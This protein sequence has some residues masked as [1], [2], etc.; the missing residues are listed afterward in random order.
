M[1]SGSPKLVNNFGQQIFHQSSLIMELNLKIELGI[2][3][4]KINVQKFVKVGL[5]QVRQKNG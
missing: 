5:L 1:I 4:Q 3:I 2:Y